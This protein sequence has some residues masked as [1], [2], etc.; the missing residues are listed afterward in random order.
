MPNASALIRVAAV[1]AL[2]PALGHAA[3]SHSEFV[4]VGCLTRTAQNTYVIKDHRSN[5]QYQLHS[6]NSTPQKTLAWQVGHELEV[7]GALASSSTSARK[8]LDVSS[9]I[10]IAATC[11][12]GQKAKS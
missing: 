2:T 1:L 3:D 12:Q 10:E 7:H 8:R 5:A 6:D 11:P 4:V 9:V